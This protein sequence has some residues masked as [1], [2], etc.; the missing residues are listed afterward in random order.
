MPKYTKKHLEAVGK[1]MAEYEEVL[2]AKSFIKLGGCDVCF[3]FPHDTA[4][5]CARCLFYSSR[6]DRD[7][8]DSDSGNVGE[9]CLSARAQRDQQQHLL[10]QL[11]KNGYE[12]REVE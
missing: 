4:R 6:N 10:L 3:S 5:F 7:C 9:E 11:A 8:M 12:Y 2:A 1:R